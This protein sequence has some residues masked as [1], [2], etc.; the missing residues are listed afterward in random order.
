MASNTDQII[1]TLDRITQDDFRGNE[2]DRLRVIES[3][4]KLISRLQYKAERLYDIT[5]SQ[6]V[7]FAALQTLLD[8]GLWAGWTN[9]GGQAKTV[10][11]LCDLCAQEIEPSLLRMYLLYLL[12][13]L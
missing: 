8:V 3:A 11:E 9:A 4:N 13:L 1:S 10:D 2:T 6:P 7:V 5:F 12:I